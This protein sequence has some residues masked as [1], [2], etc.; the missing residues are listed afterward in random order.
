[1]DLEE[2]AAGELWPHHAC[3]IMVTHLGGTAPTA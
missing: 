1:V 3:L 2:F